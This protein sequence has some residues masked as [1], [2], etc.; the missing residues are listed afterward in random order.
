MENNKYYNYYSRKSISELI[1]ELKQL[2]Q[3]STKIDWY[4]ALIQ[5]LLE[6]EISEVERSQIDNIINGGGKTLSQ[7]LENLVDLYKSNTINK[8]EFEALKRE[9]FGDKK[10]TIKE[11][12]KIITPINLATEIKVKTSSNTAPVKPK[13]TNSTS[14]LNLTGQ[15]ILAG[16]FFLIIIICSIIKNESK[17]NNSTQISTP[18]SSNNVEPSSSDGTNNSYSGKVCSYCGKHFSGSHYTHLGKMVDCHESTD[19]NSIGIFC[20]LECCTNARRR[21]C[22]SCY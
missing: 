4:E 13:N 3:D 17:N 19:P 11:I 6:T 12:P 16:V 21:S 8:E 15:K 10:S 14:P 2:K 22:P 5:Y 18:P 7:G 1:T 9:L 20:S